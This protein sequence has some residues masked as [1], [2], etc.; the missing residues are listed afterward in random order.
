MATLTPRFLLRKP[1]AGDNVNV[2]T[3]IA[4][5]MDT[6]DLAM[7][8]LLSRT[9]YTGANNQLHGPAE[10]RVTGL[11]TPALTLPANRRLRMEC[12]AL[13]VNNDVSNYRR[14]LGHVRINNG[15]IDRWVDV[16]LNGNESRLCSSFVYYEPAAGV[17]TFDATISEN[18]GTTAVAIN[19]GV[20][21]QFLVWDIGSTLL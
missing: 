18:G 8:R 16:T 3:D 21:A 2:T 6:I 9:T 12:K 17:H 19:T 1:A 10:V 15:A 5:T 4:N 7:P 13:L 14:F 20:I 11:V